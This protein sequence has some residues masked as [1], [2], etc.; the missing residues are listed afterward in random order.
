VSLLRTSVLVAA[1]VVGACGT[2]APGPPAAV[3]TGAPPRPADVLALPN[4]P[5]SIK[6]AAIGDSG[7]G[8]RA[9]Y[10]VSAQM[11]AFR[12]VFGFD[13]VVML[14]DNIYDGATAQDYRQKFELPYKTFL[15]AGLNFY[16]VL[17]N[18]DDVKQPSYAP[19]HMG[20]ARYYTFRADPSLLARLTDTDLQF[21][22]LDTETLDRTQAAWVDRE[23]GRSDA[24]WKIPA[25][26]RP[27]YT[28]GRYATPARI[29]RSVLEPVFQRRGVRLA[30]SGHEHFYE[31]TTPQAGITYFISG[32]AGSLRVGDIRRTSLVASG[33]DTDYHFMLFE[34]TRDSL[35]FQAISRTGR[36]V[37]A[38]EIKH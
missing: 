4:R 20:G 25:F 21:F 9:Q 24:R 33:F 3:E 38:G 12:A 13:F 16:A 10:D 2:D 1:L 36:S 27:I 35:Y 8:D 15:D 28:S 7:R 11:A 30:L 34:V 29:L 26:H 37:D 31:R 22:M 23:M 18:H 32:G 14:G 6:F 5:D 19:F 17:G